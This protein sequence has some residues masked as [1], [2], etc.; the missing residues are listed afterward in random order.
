MRIRRP[1]NNLNDTQIDIIIAQNKSVRGF[2]C[3]QMMSF[4]LSDLKFI[5]EQKKKKLC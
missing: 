5:D 2:V 1:T 3:V 4:A